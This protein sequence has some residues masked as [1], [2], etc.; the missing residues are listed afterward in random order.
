M[1]CS[2]NSSAR[3][4]TTKKGQKNKDKFY[5]RVKQKIKKDGIYKLTSK[6]F[7]KV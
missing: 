2:K 6:G 5:E 7:K 4:N 3:Y 1:D